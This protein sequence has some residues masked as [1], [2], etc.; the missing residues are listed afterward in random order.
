MSTAVSIVLAVMTERYARLDQ[1]CVG[2]GSCAVA[3]A[4]DPACACGADVTQEAAAASA[5]AMHSVQ[6]LL[7]AV[8]GAVTNTWGRRGGLAAGVTT[9]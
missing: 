7:S 9:K 2:L 6:Y 5:F 8:I 1:G 4:E 3:A